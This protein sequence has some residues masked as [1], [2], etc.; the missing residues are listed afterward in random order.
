MLGES[1]LEDTPGGFPYGCSSR[2]HVP[3]PLYFIV[4]PGLNID[5]VNI[6]QSYKHIYY[7]HYT[8]YTNTI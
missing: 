1:D 6:G 7:I 5:L 4:K 8:V 3:H 2:H